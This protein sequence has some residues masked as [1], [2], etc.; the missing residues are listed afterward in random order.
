MNC[1]DVERLIEDYRSGF[2]GGRKHR[3][4]ERHISGCAG[5]RRLLD[6]D[7]ALDQA[8]ESWQPPEPGP[9]FPDRVAR[10]L[11]SAPL[12]APRQ[13]RVP[14]ALVIGLAV[15]L[16]ASLSA[17]LVFLLPE[18]GLPS[19]VPV[20]SGAAIWPPA[21][22]VPQEALVLPAHLELPHAPAEAEPIFW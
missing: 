1:K 18:S 21:E 7:E 13:V 22:E 8:L 19:D 16:L 9:D 17:N 15:L 5:C 6:D 3:A 12:E 11:P 10:R 4:L 2:L 14:L 20:V